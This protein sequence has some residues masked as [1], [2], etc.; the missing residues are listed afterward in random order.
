MGR[1]LR[2]VRWLTL[3]VFHSTF[4]IQ[5]SKFRLRRQE[6]SSFIQHSKFKIQ[7]SAINGQGAEAKDCNRENREISRNGNNWEK[8]NW[9]HPHDES[10]KARKRL[11]F[12]APFR[13]FRGKT[14]FIVLMSPGFS[15]Q[16]F[17]PQKCA[18]YAISL[19][20]FIFCGFCASLRLT[21]CIPT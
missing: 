15:L 18:R 3:C 12:F 5:H 20:A 13:A 17:L 10:V 7:N 9:V 14:F 19:M 21:E 11:I 16:Y 6:D 8:S 1:E 4:K 2:A